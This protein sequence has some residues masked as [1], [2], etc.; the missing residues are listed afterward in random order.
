MSEPISVLVV[1]DNAL[2]RV[3]LK[4]TVGD[5]PDMMVA[6]EAANGSEALERYRELQP[7]VVTMDYRMP[8]EDGLEATRKILAEFPDARIVFLS[9]YEGEEDIWNA[10]QAGVLGYLSKTGAIENVIEAIREVAA[11]NSYFPATI[12]GKLEARKEQDSLTPREMEVLKLIVEG[13]SNKEIMA[14]LS[15]SASTV[16]VHVSNMLEKLGVL[17]RTQAAVAAVKRGIIHLD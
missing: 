14:K 17:D 15:L 8:N 11:G 3:G 1:D 7:G 4:D 6:G 9:V 10:W 13:C 12:A 2:L 16:R 5:E